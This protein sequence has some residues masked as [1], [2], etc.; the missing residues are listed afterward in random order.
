MEGTINVQQFVEYLQEND[1][2]IAPISQVTVDKRALQVKALKKPALTYKEVAE[3]GLWGD[4]S[5]KRAYQLGKQYGREGELLK[6][7]KHDNSPEKILT[8]AVKRIAILRRV[9]DVAELINEMEHGPER[10]HL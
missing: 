6:P 7:G 4:I 8:Q 1:L 5:Q 3:A 9:E 10:M 2:V